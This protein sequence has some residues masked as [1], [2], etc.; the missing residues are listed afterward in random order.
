MAEEPYKLLIMDSIM[1][2]FRTD[3]SGGCKHLG[4]ALTGSGRML[5][6]GAK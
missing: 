3:F 5:L 2:N 6:P 1:G 4:Q